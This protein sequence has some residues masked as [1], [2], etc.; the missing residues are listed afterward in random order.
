VRPFL[1]R[2]IWLFLSALLAVVVCCLPRICYDQIS[3]WLFIPSLFLFCQINR[4][5]KFQFPLTLVVVAFVLWAISG[6]VGLGSL[7]IPQEVGAVVFSGLSD[8]AQGRQVGKRAKEISLTYGLPSLNI[9][10]DSF[11]SDSEARSWLNSPNNTRSVLVYGKP[12]KYRAV[13][14]NRAVKQT[15][16]A[17]SLS[18]E[19]N[20]SKKNTLEFQENLGVLKLDTWLGVPLYLRI[21]PPVLPLST[22]SQDLL[23][24]YLGWLGAAFEV[25]EE[26]ELEEDRRIAIIEKKRSALFELAELKGAWASRVSRGFGYYELANLDFLEYFI[27]ELDPLTVKSDRLLSAAMRSFQRAS[28][29]VDAGSY[30]ILY[31]DIFNN[32]GVALLVGA[33][34]NDDVEKARNWLLRSLAAAESSADGALSAQATLLNLEVLERVRGFVADEKSAS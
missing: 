24:H 27:S 17:L 30:P 26:S 32:A 20:K 14:A 12:G 29:H 10:K 23:L 6:V 4:R 5:Y 7:L 11:S 13:I 1:I 15:I 21:T 34:N 28:A 25:R 19:K 3:F 9:L 18:F 22:A 8:S 2:H 33:R 31:A 16:E